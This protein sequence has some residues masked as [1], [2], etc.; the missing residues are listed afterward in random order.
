MPRAGQREGRGE[1]DTIWVR[2][3]FWFA[4]AAGVRAGVGHAPVCGVCGWVG[5]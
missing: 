5:G 2:D 1:V 4:R 3:L